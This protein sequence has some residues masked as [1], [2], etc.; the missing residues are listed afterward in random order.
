[1][2]LPTRATSV[3][4]DISSD[5]CICYAYRLP[6]SDAAHGGPDNQG[7][8]VTSCSS[9]SFFYLIPSTCCTKLQ[10]PGHCF[11]VSASA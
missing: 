2:K 4:D 8:L 11:P 9:L 5:C 7:E 10:H 6:A 3:L 1:M